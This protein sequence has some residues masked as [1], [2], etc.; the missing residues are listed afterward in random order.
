MA[1]SAAAAP[2]RVVRPATRGSRAA[3][4][5]VGLLAGL[6]VGLG[7]ALPAVL[8]HAVDQVLRGDGAGHWVWG[9]AAVVAGQVLVGAASDVLAAVS[10]ARVT[11]AVR[12]GAVR[13]VLAARVPGGGDLVTRLVG[14]A[15]D[16]GAVPGAAATL[17]AAVGA[18]VGGVIALF[19]TDPWLAAA[20]LLGAPP[21]A[22]LVHRFARA[23]SDSAARYQ[24]AQG[25]I[26]ARLVEAIGG[27]RTVAAA[28][29]EERE[30]R[31]VLGPLP[32]LSAQGHRMWQVQGRA[33]AQAAVL[34]PLLQILVLAIGGLR[35][36]Q[37]ALS[38]GGLLAA[39]RYALLATGIG[40]V[41]GQLG[42]LVRGRAAARRI[43]EVLA[44]PA[45]A[46]GRDRLPEGGP[47]TLELRGVTVVRG[48]ETVLDRLDLT[49]PGGTCLA[50]VGPSGAGKSVLAELA[51]RLADPD[52]GTV[53]LDGAPLAALTRA[54][55]RDAVGYAFERPVLLGDTLAD[56]IAFGPRELTTEAVTDAARAAGADGFLRLLPRGYATPRAAAPLSGGEVQRLGLARAFA[57]G[58]R[59][60]VL[61][62]ATSSL[63]TVTEL[64]VA[65]SLLHDPRGRTRLLT[66]HRAGT[67]ARADLVAWLDA[68]RL[69]A[70]APHH[71]LWQDPDYRA[72]FA[73]PDESVGAAVSAVPGAPRG[74]RAP[75]P[76][77][78]V[79]DKEGSRRG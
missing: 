57:H 61:D 66:T 2:P 36:A 9:C 79:A 4:G 74:R 30:A 50:V 13:H 53:L 67:A 47:G 56:A 20:F 49:V 73:A 7:L 68:G 46:H 3:V 37:G 59:L 42:A 32:E 25:R 17:P 10:G 58:G 41:V 6:S 11:A 22:L 75:E 31:R 70:L 27:A 23:S 26:A 52:Q 40:A 28:R 35:L 8:G 1:D 51:G 54:E 24:D 69:R 5:A 43:G 44:V 45:P 72:L 18:P 21:L 16:A 14:N 19:L 39:S 65:H 64:H 63:D 78:D 48:G 55:L 62:D 34:V 77:V 12:R 38:V 71:T 33:T 76:P 15:A 29:T 60:L